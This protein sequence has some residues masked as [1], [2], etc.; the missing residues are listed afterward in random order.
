MPAGE[1]HEGRGGGQ[2][3]GDSDASS[4]RRAKCRADEPERLGVRGPTLHTR[5]GH[6]LARLCWR[7]CDH[8]LLAESRVHGLPHSFTQPDT[9]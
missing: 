6:A 3:R 7:L 5:D 1:E 4:S 2:G 9:Q 8:A